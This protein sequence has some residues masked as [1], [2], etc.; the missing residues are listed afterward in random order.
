MVDDKVEFSI[1]NFVDLFFKDGP[2][3]TYLD[4]VYGIA[5]HNYQLKI[6]NVMFKET[7][8]KKM[9]EDI[10]NAFYEPEITTTKENVDFSIQVNRPLGFRQFATLYPMSFAISNETIQEINSSGGSCK[11]FKFEKRKKCPLTHNPYLHLFIKNFKRKNIPN[12]IT[13]RSR[14]IS[15]NIDGE[16]PK[17]RCNYS[18][19]QPTRLKT[20]QKRKKTTK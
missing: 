19:E 3:E 20:V 11:H 9:L 15:V 14:F 2:F 12:S 17:N 8:S 5:T 18:K 7:T 16:S 13:F 1:N 6:Y 10:Y 4:K